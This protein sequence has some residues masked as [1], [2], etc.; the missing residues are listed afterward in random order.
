M[1]ARRRPIRASRV[2][3]N[4]DTEGS[5]IDLALPGAC[6][7]TEAAGAWDGDALLIEDRESAHGQGGGPPR[8]IADRHG[9]SRGG[10][11]KLL[12]SK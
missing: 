12:S 3:S 10:P 2:F 9:S 6:E 1:W 5:W 4:L 8:C 11:G 7:L